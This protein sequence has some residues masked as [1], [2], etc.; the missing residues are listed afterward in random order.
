MLNLYFGDLPSAKVTGDGWFDNCIDFDCITSD[1]GRRIIKKIQGS[2][3]FDKNVTVH[4]IF[5][6]QPP[7]KL[8]GGIKSLLLLYASD[9]FIM[10]LASMGDNC[11][12]FLADIASVKDITVCSDMIRPIFDNSSLDVVHIMNND[13]YAHNSKE[14]FDCYCDVIEKGLYN[15]R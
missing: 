11:L 4:P 7:E 10:D 3:V 5:G 13:S 2:E 12:P 6:G 9:D 15:V 8:A 1:F 14:Y